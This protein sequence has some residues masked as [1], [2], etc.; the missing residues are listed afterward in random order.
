VVFPLYDDNPFTLP[1]PPYV[2]W[3]LIAINVAVFLMTVRLPEARQIEIATFYGVVPAMVTQSVI[4]HHVGFADL[5]LLTGMFLHASWGHILGNMIYLWVFGDDIEEAFGPLRFLAFYLLAGIASA[6]AFV[7]VDPNGGMPLIGASGAISGVLAGYLMLR[8]CA[9]VLVF[10]LRIVVRL[11]AYWVIGA[12]AVLQFLSLASQPDDGVAY[13][14]HVG[15]LA[16]GVGLFL[17]LRPAGLKLFD[18]AGQ[19][20]SSAVVT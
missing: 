7:I 14:A 8:P 5:G 15:G 3:T 2:T 1:R 11:R 6:L 9:K 18:C 12:W 16:A 19:E 4:Y 20:E 13:I 17:L 10:V